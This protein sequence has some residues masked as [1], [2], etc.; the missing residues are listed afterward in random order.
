VRDA[1]ELVL[2]FD[3]GGVRCG[4]RALDVQEI[5]RAVTILPVPEA[6]PAIEGVINYRG[7]LIP[8]LDVRRRLGLEQRTLRPSD[9]LIV[10]RAE[11]KMF[12]LRVDNVSSVEPVETIEP[13]EAIV[14]GAKA[15]AGITRTAAGLALI[16]DLQVF[17]EDLPQ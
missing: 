5:C 17:V 3:A 10:A 12:A 4:M 14:H 15:I 1:N 7:R 16:Y 13:V 8:V 2:L 6:P 9:H 11:A